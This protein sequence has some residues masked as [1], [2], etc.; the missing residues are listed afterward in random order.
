[1]AKFLDIFTNYTSMHDVLYVI[2]IYWK[3]KNAVI[4][5]IYFLG[6]N[7]GENKEE[8]MF[9][10]NIDTFQTKILIYLNLF[11]ISTNIFLL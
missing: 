2:S 1:M 6:K 4:K 8:K 9:V 10:K 5:V 7:T 11:W 3:K